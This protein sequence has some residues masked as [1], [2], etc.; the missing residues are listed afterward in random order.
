MKSRQV[1]MFPS[2]A[3]T[4]LSLLCVV[5][6]LFTGSCHGFTPHPDIRTHTAINSAAVTARSRFPTMLQ[7]YNENGNNDRESIMARNN[8][9][10]CVKAFL[11]QRAIQS[12]MFLLAECRDPHSGKWIED[13]L[14]LPDLHN[15]HGTGAFNI[16][17]FATWDMVL[18][19]M[20]EMPKGT[21]WI[22]FGFVLYCR[23][24]RG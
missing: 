14:G 17:R 22:E 9:R 19:E 20:M 3:A 1:V 2:A 11:T 8:A 15:F 23:C 21:W 6:V 16:S 7:A 5:A 24:L 18:L 12:F 10:T 4:L 13:F